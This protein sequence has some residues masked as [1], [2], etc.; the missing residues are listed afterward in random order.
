MILQKWII[1]PDYYVAI[2]N[3][4]VHIHT[5]DF[6]LLYHS[7]SFKLFEIREKEKLNNF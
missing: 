4:L 7:V 1:I 3:I 6:F 2:K 5:Y